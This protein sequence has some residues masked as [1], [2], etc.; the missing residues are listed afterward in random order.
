MIP[1]F[2]LGPDEAAWRDQLATALPGARFPLQDPGVDEALRASPL[3]TIAVARR[4]AVAVANDSGT[5][6][7]LAAADIPLVSLFGPT[8][9]A[10]FAP[11]VSRAA[12]I[13]AQDHGDAAIEAIPV[14]AVL[15][16][17]RSLAK[18]ASGAAAG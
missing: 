4:L 13:R 14:D 5:G 16:T 10:K 6:H 11:Y 12:V 1:A 2:L 7:M 15:E 8:D 18:V 9:P 3:F 17:V